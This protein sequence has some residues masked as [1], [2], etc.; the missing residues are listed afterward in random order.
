MEKL[1]VH[2][3]YYEKLLVVFCRPRHWKRWQAKEFNTE[4]SRDHDFDLPGF[5]I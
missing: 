1:A 2:F 3:K 5:I 4:N